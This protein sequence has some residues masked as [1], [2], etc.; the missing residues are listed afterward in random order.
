MSEINFNIHKKCSFK[1]YK[2]SNPLSKFYLWVIIIWKRNS[3]VRKYKM[4]ELSYSPK[5]MIILYKYLTWV[6]VRHTHYFNKYKT[7]ELRELCA[8][9]NGVGGRMIN[10][11]RWRRKMDYVL[12][13]V[14]DYYIKGVTII[15]VTRAI[16]LKIQESFWVSRIQKAFLNIKDLESLLKC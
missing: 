12:V 11:R 13:L 3:S 15:L 1:E 2:L 9:V 7:T 4:T 14:D 8:R 10:F 16:I 6:Y 5:N